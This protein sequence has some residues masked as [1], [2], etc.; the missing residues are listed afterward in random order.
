MFIT[1]DNPDDPL[2]APIFAG[3][4]D[5]VHHELIPGR[6][7]AWSEDGTPVTIE[8]GSDSSCVVK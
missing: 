8:V 4:A 1:I 5:D 7:A 6:Y 2:T 3:E